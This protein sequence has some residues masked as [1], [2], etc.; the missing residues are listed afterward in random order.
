MQL[1]DHFLHC[2]PSVVLRIIGQARRRVS[3][4]IL[5]IMEYLVHQ[6]FLFVGFK[7]L[8]GASFLNTD[9]KTVF[10]FWKKAMF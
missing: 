5:E 4:Y 7:S 1:K 9:G 3:F 8:I 2:Q 10:H 6:H